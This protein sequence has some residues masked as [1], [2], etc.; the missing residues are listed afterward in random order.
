MYAVNNDIHDRDGERDRRGAGEADGIADGERMP[1]APKDLGSTEVFPQTVKHNCNGRFIVRV[2]R[3]R[4]HHLHVAGA[5]Q[6]G[7]W[8][9]PSTSAGASGTGDY[10]IRESISKIKTFRNFKE[11]KTVKP[12]ISAAEGLFGGHLLAMRGARL[13]GILQLGRGRVHPQD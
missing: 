1:V 7:V 4:V 12:P 9:T 11:N 3:R 5:A 2:R 8:L 10:A 6:Q 13:R